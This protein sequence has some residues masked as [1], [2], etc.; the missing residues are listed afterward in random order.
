MID[1]TSGYQP[2]K[3]YTIGEA[4]K[5]KRG[6]P[7]G[8]PGE[9]HQARK[10]G[11]RR[12]TDSTPEEKESV[13]QRRAEAEAAKP[14]DLEAAC[15]KE[16][17]KSIQRH[18]WTEDTEKRNSF[19][20]GE[21]FRDVYKALFQP[22]DNITLP[23]NRKSL[24]DY[25]SAEE[26]REAATA[27]I[28]ICRMYGILPTAEAFCIM[29]GIGK[30]AFYKWM[31]GT[32]RGTTAENVTTSHK[33]TAKMIRESAQ[34]YI[35]GALATDRTGILAIA[36]NDSFV[37]LEWEKKKIQDAAEVLTPQIAA[38]DIAQRLA[39]RTA[40]SLEAPQKPRKLLDMVIPYDD[41]D[42]DDE[43]N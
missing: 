31:N 43:N 22:P 27:Y 33:E 2:P 17:E 12:D 34:E 38:Q 35:R 41:S 1:N 36:N 16:F 7:P 28:S 9:P 13:K 32:A 23:N 5:R 21:C 40:G 15:K 20:F 24:L 10:P 26:V 25:N 18:G 37:G 29:T 11:S 14:E 8:I 3:Y 19:Q 39:A 30:D 6:R 4:H 42:D